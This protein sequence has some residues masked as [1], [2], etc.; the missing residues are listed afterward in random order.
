MG[1]KVVIDGVEYVPK[2]LV[3]APLIVGVRQEYEPI[4]VEGL[5]SC[6]YGRYLDESYVTVRNIKGE[7][8]EIKIPGDILTQILEAIRK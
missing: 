2:E 5:Y 8:T 6:R 3:V 1:K 7:D 4:L